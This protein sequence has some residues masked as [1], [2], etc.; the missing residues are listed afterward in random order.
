[1]SC[2]GPRVIAGRAA[3][4]SD[5]HYAELARSATVSQLLTAVNLE[6]RPEPDPDQ[7]RPEPTAVDHQDV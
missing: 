1:M 7:H 3:D 4:G 6:P 2:W 5:E